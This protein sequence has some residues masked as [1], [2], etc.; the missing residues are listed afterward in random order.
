MG[1]SNLEGA[2]EKAASEFSK[3]IIAAVKSATLQELMALQAA[4][5]G[6]SKARRK[7]GRPRGL[8]I[9]KA[10]KVAKKATAAA[11]KKKRVVKNY[12]KCAYPG[13]EKNRFPRGKGYCGDHW[14]MSLAGKIKGEDSHKKK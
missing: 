11:P 8:K 14:R 10:K 3:V 6:A 12:P 9:A 2:I 5:V 7:P 4:G 13:C 1:K